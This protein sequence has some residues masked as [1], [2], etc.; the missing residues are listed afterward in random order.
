MTVST[1]T[2]TEPLA[3]DKSAPVH[4]IGVGGIGMSGLARVLLASGYQVSGSDVAENEN[5]RSLAGQGAAIY[6]GHDGANVPAG[7][8]VIVSTAIDDENP[9]VETARAQGLGIYHRSALLR[10][11]LQ[12][13][14]LGHEISIGVTGTHGKTTTTGMAGVA[15]AA[16]GLSPTVVVGGHI[17]DLE[18]NALVSPAHQYAVAELDESDGTIVQYMPDITYIANLELDHADHYADGLAGIMDTFRVFLK[19]LKPGSRV[20]FN[21][22]DP[23]VKQLLDDVPEGVEKILLAPGEIF[24]GREPETT[25]WLKNVRHHG[26]G[27]YQ[28]YVYKS[29]RL[30]G[31][32]H[33]NVPGRHN[34][35]NA[36]AALALGDQA[37]ADF[38]LMADALRKFQGMR[39]RFEKVGEVD[40]ARF[41]DDYAHHPT[42]IQATLKAA[43]DMVKGTEGRVIAVFQPHRYSRLK[44]L[45]DE[46]TQSFADADHVILTDVYAAHEKPIEGTTT[47]A[48]ARAVP[49]EHVAYVPSP[50]GNFDQIRSQLKTLVRPGDVV[51]SM[52]A[53]N[54]TRLLRDW[55]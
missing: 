19:H 54:I 40:N 24:T 9:E 26:H 5:T 44:A 50:D 45:W 52:G 2:P 43:R 14:D 27:C 28:G 25:Y 1:R 12:G 10:E 13:S 17:P 32:L 53:G 31:E 7:A 41:Y 30:L 22:S 42:E 15:L 36:L 4:F 3:L 21:L 48:F 23:N 49:H 6:K 38:N 20:I 8:V 18:T 33:L 34:L 35:A 55:Q 47:E 46:F 51:L 39:R 11:V 29:G 37:G 16:G